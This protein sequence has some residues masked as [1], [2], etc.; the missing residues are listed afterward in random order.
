MIPP[1]Q[2][3]SDPTAN[4][5]IRASGAAAGNGPRGLTGVISGVRSTVEEGQ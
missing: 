5:R 3:S 1:D 2:H 4:G